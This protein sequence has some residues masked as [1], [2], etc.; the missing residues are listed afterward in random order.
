MELRD[1]QGYLSGTQSVLYM[2]VVHWDPTGHSQSTYQCQAVLRTYPSPPICTM[3]YT[4]ISWD[5]TLDHPIPS[6]PLLHWDPMGVPH[7]TL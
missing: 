2:Y 4:E 7:I 1:P 5:V 3:W 6:V